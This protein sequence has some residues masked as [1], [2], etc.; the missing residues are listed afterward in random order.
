M[1]SIDKKTGIVPD[2]AIF[3]KFESIWNDGIMSK[4]M[5]KCHNFRE[6]F[7]DRLS[8]SINILG[9]DSIRIEDQANKS[10]DE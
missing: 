5:M 6:V 8:F 2:N 1:Y 4:K 10:F 3:T 7:N 9:M